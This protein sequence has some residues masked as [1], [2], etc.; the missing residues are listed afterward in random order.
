MTFIMKTSTV[1]ALTLATGIA[2]AAPKQLITHNQ[3][4]YESSAF[5][6]GVI[7]PQHPTKPQSDGY[8]PWTAVRMAC[9][10]PYTTNGKCWAVI[11]MGANTPNPI[12]VGKV[13]ID[14]ETGIITPSVLKANGFTF[15]ATG[16][17]EAMITQP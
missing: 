1:I 11:K 8:L 5:V 10:G 14:L 7:P 16:P 6:G 17:G 3:T 9:F 12:E 13:T 15:T 2:I 4:N